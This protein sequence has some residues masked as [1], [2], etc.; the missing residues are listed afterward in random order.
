MVNAVFSTP[1]PIQQAAN[2]ISSSSPAAGGL[3][4]PTTNQYPPQEPLGGSRTERIP[5]TGSKPIPDHIQK[6][7]EEI[8]KVRKNNRGM[9]A[10]LTLGREF[11]EHFTSDGSFLRRDSPLFQFYGDIR[12]FKWTTWGHLVG[13]TPTV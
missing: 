10:R 1:K 5:F 3:A 7:A 4:T 12:L 11:T 9:P 13:W 8:K 2:H 6:L